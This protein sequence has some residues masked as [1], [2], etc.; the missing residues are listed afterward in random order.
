MLIRTGYDLTFEFPAPTAMTLLL[1]VHPER[2]VD[3]VEPE[4]LIV[5]PE[6]PVQ[7]F[8]D[9][10]GNR[11]AKILAPAG[12]VRMRSESRVRD[13]GLVDAQNPSAQQVPVADLRADVL[14]FLL[15]SRYC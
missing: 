8:T 15:P 6:L 13:E 11:A 14:Q 4:K 10:F 5:E 7:D 1:Y 12:F 3:L 9:V 2:A